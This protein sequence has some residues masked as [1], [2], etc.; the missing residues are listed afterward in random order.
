MFQIQRTTRNLSKH[1]P[2]QKEAD[3]LVVTRSAEDDISGISPF[4]EQSHRNK[5]DSG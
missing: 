4:F 3:L 5:I 2:F 1:V